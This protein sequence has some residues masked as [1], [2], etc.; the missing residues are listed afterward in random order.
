MP[1]LKQ[2]KGVVILEFTLCFVI[3]WIVF[4]GVIEFSRTLV[5]WNAAQEATRM[6]AKMASTCNKNATQ[7]FQINSKL[8]Y[9][10]QSAGQVDLSE[11]MDWLQL[12]YFPVGCSAN[13][14]EQVQARLNDVRLQ[15]MF[16]GFAGFPVEILLPEN[17]TTVMR[18]SMQ[19]Y[20]AGT[21]GGLNEE[22]CQ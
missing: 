12:D 17:R 15:L 13:T 22:T 1:K 9:L 5:S 7:S 16:S 10:L 11:R 14:C 19:N 20:L 8:S 4:M 3:F 21:D 18:E 2:Q 6:A